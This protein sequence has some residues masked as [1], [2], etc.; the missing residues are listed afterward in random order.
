MGRQQRRREHEG[1][2][3]LAGTQRRD[4]SCAE[5]RGLAPVYPSIEISIQTGEKSKR[6]Y[7][8]NVRNN[9]WD[10]PPSQTLSLIGALSEPGY[11][12]SRQDDQSIVR[13]I[14]EVA[15]VASP[16]ESCQPILEH[17]GM[18]MEAPRRRIDSMSR[19]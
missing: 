12:R 9:F 4:R 1:G 13:Q 3:P 2:A 14:S 10:E 16:R 5:Y 7:K 18:S 8:E 15:R 11:C 17:L 19:R 6:F